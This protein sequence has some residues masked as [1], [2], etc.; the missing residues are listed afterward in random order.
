MDPFNNAG[1]KLLTPRSSVSAEST[2]PVKSSP[3]MG[4]SVPLLIE[5]TQ[6]PVEFGAYCENLEFSLILKDRTQ[7]YKTLQADLNNFCSKKEPISDLHDL[8]GLYAVKLPRGE[9]VRATIVECLTS[10]DAEMELLDFS[11][12]LRR[13]HLDQIVK[14]HGR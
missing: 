9:W 7:I 13:C 14:I 6:Y 4:P 10:S 12:Q 5:S 1:N 8:S 2:S 3:F 11:S